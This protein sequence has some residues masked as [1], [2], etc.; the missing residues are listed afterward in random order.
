MVESAWTE[1]MGQFLHHL[2]PDIRK[3]TRCLEKI[4]F[5]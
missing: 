3:I 2:D 4:N 1:D 5:K